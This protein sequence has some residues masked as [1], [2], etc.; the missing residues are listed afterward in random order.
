MPHHDEYHKY[1]GCGNLTTG[2]SYPML[3]RMQTFA[4]QPY[5]I[6]RS[7]FQWILHQSLV[8]DERYT[9]CGLVGTSHESKASVLVEKVAMIKDVTDIA[10]TLGIWQELDIACLGFF[11]FEHEQAIP[12]LVEAMPDTYVE[13]QVRLAEKGRLDLLA[14]M[15]D[16]LSSH[17]VKKDLELIE[18]GH[19]DLVV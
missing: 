3:R 7:A 6:S 17:V 18:D 19:A 16:K 9:F 13:L 15:C 12:A 11:H 14:L 5:Y 10:H 1:L 2:H 4:T 8:A